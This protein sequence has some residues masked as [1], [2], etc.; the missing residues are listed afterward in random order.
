MLCADIYKCSFLGWGLGVGVAG[1][2]YF[3]AGVEIGKKYLLL[4]DTCDVV[5]LGV[6][7]GGVDGFDLPT[8]VLQKRG[9]VR[10]VQSES[11]L[12]IF[13]TDSTPQVLSCN[14]A[15][16]VCKCDMHREA[17]HLLISCCLVMPDCAA[18][19]ECCWRSAA[20]RSSSLTSWEES[21]WG[22][23]LCDSRRSKGAL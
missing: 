1:V 17:A 6:V 15:F 13:R 18:I 8:N 2:A 4:T 21:G 14:V 16:E 12:K 3:M 10:E 19:T 7:W 5:G 9:K 11:E 22:M 23:G 20:S